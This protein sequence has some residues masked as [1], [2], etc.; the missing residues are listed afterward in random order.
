MGGEENGF[1][2]GGSELGD[3]WELAASP[4]T[5]V[6]VGRTGNGKSATG[7]SILGKRVF[8]SKS[9]PSAVTSTCELQSTTR[10]DGRCIRVVDTPGLFD[11]AQPPEFIME[12]IIKCLHLAKDG[13][14]GLLLVLASRNRFT[15]EE[16]AAVETI[17]TIFGDKVVNYMIVLFT[18]GDDLEESGQ[19]LDDYL[20]EGAPEFLKSFVKKCGNRKIL[21]DN[22]T[23]DKSAKELQ[24]SELMNLIDDM[25]AANGGIPYTTDLF[26]EAQELAARK[27]ESGLLRPAG[28]YLTKDFQLMKEQLEK[29][30]KEQLDQF[31]V[32]VED[33]IRQSGENLER[34]LMVEMEAREEIERTARMDKEKA[35]A[36]IRALRE[37]LERANKEREEFMEQMK[38]HSSKCTIL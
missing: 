23:K 1:I 33:R 7:N 16:E 11:P 29:T 4:T 34:K 36:D 22:K 26:K 3:D 6:L 32:M 30:Y 14:H 24:V 2:M 27:Q 21:F 8:I 15:P 28:G 35:E 13:V 31:K 37:A 17:Q 38:N 10:H 12:E 18:G 9:S 5:L 20:S 19:T 25:V